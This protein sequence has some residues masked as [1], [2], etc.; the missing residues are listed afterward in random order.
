MIE[1]LK[2]RNTSEDNSSKDDI[3]RDIADLPKTPSAD[4]SGKK[5]IVTGGNGGLGLACSAALAEAGAEVFILA[6]NQK[7]S[8]EAVAAIKQAGGQAHAIA[9]DIVDLDAMRGV[10]ADLPL[11]SILVNNAGINRL[12]DFINVSEKDFDA[13]FNVNVRAAFFTSQEFTRR[14]LSAQDQGGPGGH[15]P[16]GSGGH[17]PGGSGGH[18]QGGSGGH[19]QSG[20]GG[21]TPGGSGGHIQS[22]AGGH[23]PGGSIINM[24]SQ[25]AYVGGKQRSVYCASKHAMEGFTKAMAW[26]LGPK[27]IRVNTICPTFFVTPLTDPMLADDSFMESVLDKIAL[28][29]V[30][31]PQDIMAAVVFLASDGSAMVT[32]S[33]LKIDG[34]WTAV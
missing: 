7:K 8:D 15:T 21:H 2:N 16:G 5:A 34:G 30:G 29:K 25:M 28:G 3:R 26:E 22:G 27:N 19:I 17:I 18:A 33:A 31:Y 12:D 9:V 10:L 1:D 6:R 13:I 20:S 11:C 14:L 23:I 4:L 24:S 32:G